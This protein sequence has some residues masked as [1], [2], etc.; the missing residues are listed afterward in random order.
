MDLELC[1]NSCVNSEEAPE[2]QL[3]FLPGPTHIPTDSSHI[4]GFWCDQTPQVC[5]L[6]CSA[7]CL[8]PPAP[9]EWKGT[10]TRRAM[11]LITTLEWYFNTK[12]TS[13]LLQ[14]PGHFD[15]SPVTAVAIAMG[16]LPSIRV[17]KKEECQFALILPPH[18][19]GKKIALDGER[20]CIKWLHVCFCSL[21]LRTS[22][23][24]SLT[25]VH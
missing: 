8:A 6:L 5:N 15:Q 3:L 18:C 12:H 4:A 10:I 14:D 1:W 13:T 7:L 23:I 9:E 21:H 19:D 22:L 25:Q 11:S 2:E 16:K 17:V 20:Y 24:K